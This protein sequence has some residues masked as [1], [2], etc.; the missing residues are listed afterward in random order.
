[1][2]LQAY[3]PARAQL[4]F[5]YIVLQSITLFMVIRFILQLK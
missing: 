5:S 2:G 3:N 1:M 4:Y